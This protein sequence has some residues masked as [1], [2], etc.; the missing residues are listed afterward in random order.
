MP[1]NILILYCAYERERYR[2][3]EKQAELNFS[4]FQG[5]LRVWQ[6][7][8][9]M[10]FVLDCRFRSV[11]FSITPSVNIFMY[12]Q[13]KYFC[14]YMRQILLIHQPF[15]SCVIF[16]LSSLYNLIR[17]KIRTNLIHLFISFVFFCRFSFPYNEYN[18][19][20]WRYFMY[21]M[22]IRQMNRITGVNIPML[23]AHLV[24][25][26]KFRFSLPSILLGEII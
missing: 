5:I 11:T 24:Q 19:F 23:C 25:M 20:F 15:Y 18:W 13:M 6:R 10:V 4:C 3:T 9:V 21:F 17:N 22:C 7:N 2:Y 14:D 1:Q 16:V 12:V 8:K 26:I